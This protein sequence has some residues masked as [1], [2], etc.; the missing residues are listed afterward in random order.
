MFS[1]ILVACQGFS[2]VSLTPPEVY[3]SEV[4]CMEK[5]LEIYQ[6][7]KDE[8]S[9]ELRGIKCYEWDDKV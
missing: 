4:M 5:G 6:L 2:C 8:P 9:M 3:S 7:S 1:L